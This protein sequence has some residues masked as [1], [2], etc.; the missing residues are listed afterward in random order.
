MSS[1]DQ[2]LR[3]VVRRERDVT[4][5]EAAQGE[6]RAQR[7]RSGSAPLYRWAFTIHK[8]AGLIGAGWLAILGLTGFF[9]NNDGWKS[10][11][12]GTAPH[13]LVT[14]ELEQNAARNVARYLQI[15]P[16]NASFRVAA[17]PRGLWRTTD[18]GAIWAPTRFE[19]GAHPQ[20]FA[21]EPDPALGWGRLFIGS[22]NGVY[23]STDRGETAHIAG[24]AG[25]R[26][27]ALAAGA[28]QTEMLG[29]LGKSRVIRFDADM[30]G[31]AETLDLSPLPEEARPE[32]V[33]LHRF[34]RS[35]HFGRGLFDAPSSRLVNEAGGLAMFVLA[36]TGLTYWGFGKWWRMQ[37]KAGVRGMSPEAKRST[38][39]WLYRT[40]AAT[41]GVICSPILLYLAFTGVVIDHDREFGGWLR[42][43]QMPKAL[44][45]PAFKLT[46]WEER[47][48][49][50][51]GY[52]GASGAFS[53]GNIFG[54]FTTADG[55]KSWA[56]EE[57]G[58]GR[59]VNG[60]NRMRR[61]G[62]RVVVIS[63]NGAPALIRGDNF[64][65]HE[66]T[67]APPEGMGGGA[68]HME[69]GKRSEAEGAAPRS[70]AQF[71][72]GGS[73]SDVS[74]Y[75]GGLLWRM[76]AKLVVTDLDGAPKKMLDATQP[77]E[78]GV[79]IF[80]WLR[81]IHT[82]TLF[83]KEWRWVNDVFA[84]LALFLVL[85]GLVRWWRQKWM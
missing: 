32:D 62:D 31:K 20:I 75:E 5:A 15:D 38:T 33:R 7:R 83:W 82:G 71:S 66:V 51:I 12:Q 77:S 37:A 79:P 76:G 78:P 23:V 8:W 65:F 17:G 54:M 68:H 21:V 46:S 47:I 44:L 43:V 50:L 49:S 63:G 24:L 39:A 73:P 80:M 36:M 69:A 64:D 61:V 34:L 85:S 84:T 67:L 59:P 10:L 25:E 57:D 4:P 3:R 16:D 53:V 28:A 30:P 81:S 48:D 60:I 22:D 9:L 29:V 58:K 55:G 42:G 45:T 74:A 1:I 27:T 56:R 40:H 13:A 35:L 19:D 2:I 52:P 14:Q 26:V 11:Q 6:R 70:A 18:A 41:I 72:G